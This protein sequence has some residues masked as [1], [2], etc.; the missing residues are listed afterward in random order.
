MYE[1]ILSFAIALSKDSFNLI[2]DKKIFIKQEEIKSNSREWIYDRNK[3]TW[4]VFRD[5]CFT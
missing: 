1:V 5:R 4:K 2:E 3:N